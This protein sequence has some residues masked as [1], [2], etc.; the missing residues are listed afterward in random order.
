MKALHA[1]GVARATPRSSGILLLVLLAVVTGVRAQTAQT[2]W[3]PLF[4]NAEPA[5]GSEYRKDLGDV[6]TSAGNHDMDTAWATLRR[7]IAWCDALQR[8]DRKIVSFADGDEY[9][10]YVAARSDDTPVEWIDI[11]CPASYYAA[12]FLHAEA[13]QWEAA[14]PPL[15][16]AID[17]APFFADAHNERGF[18]FNQMGRRDEAIAEYKIALALGGEHPRSAYV[19]PIALRGI[20]WALIEDGDLPGARQAYERSLE[21]DPGNKLAL[22]E[23][24]Y[25]SGLEKAK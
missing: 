9:E 16:R 3:T 20:G 6:W 14:L 15:Q 4:A 17:I 8:P 18:V 25:I 21:L 24:E 10:A 12:G 13:R 2:T 11:A 1:C 22:G 7:V 5:L 23:L 19:R